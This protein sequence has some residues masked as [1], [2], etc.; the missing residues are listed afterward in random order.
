MIEIE[1]GISECARDELTIPLR[2]TGAYWRRPLAA[3]SERTV[4][5]IPPVKAALQILD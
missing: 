2:H 1:A 3:G 4:K 5:G